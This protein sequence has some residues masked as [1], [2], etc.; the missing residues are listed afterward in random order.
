M[1][2]QLVQSV[3]GHHP[4]VPQVVVR[5]PVERDKV[6]VQAVDTGDSSRGIQ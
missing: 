2:G 1:P 6:E 4:P 3:N 5:A